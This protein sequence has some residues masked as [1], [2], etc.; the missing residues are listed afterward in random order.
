[1]KRI[2][3][4]IAQIRA[5]FLLLG[6]LLVFAGLSTVFKYYPGLEE[7]DWLQ[8]FL[9][10]LGVIMAHISVNLFNEYS[11]YNTKIDFNT[12]RTPFSGGTG[13]LVKG[14]T[15]PRDVLTAAIITLLVAFSIGIYFTLVSHWI[16]IVIALFGV[17]TIIFY[18]TILARFMLGELF[19]GLALGSL[20]IIGTYIAMAA[21][22]DMKVSELIPLPVLIISIPPGILTS[23]LLLLNEF[24]DTEADKNGGRYHIVIHLGKQVTAWI[25]ATG[26]FITYFILALVPILGFSSPWLFISLI[27]IPLAIKGVITTILHHNDPIKIVSAIKANVIIVLATNFL[28]GL[29]LLL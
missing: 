16:I 15:K 18:T 2:L 1:M 12:I 19:S 22:P 25:Y 5:N 11:D 20:V 26:V 23:L 27:T 7:F 14:E 17:F 3:T 4:W 28:I 21:T 29:G 10:T 9:I 13:L 8:A 6:V 24:P